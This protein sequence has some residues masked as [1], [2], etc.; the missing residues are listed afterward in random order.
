M[1]NTTRFRRFLTPLLAGLLAASAFS[2]QAKI[3]QIRFAVDP[4]YPPFES[5][6]PDGSL[7][8]FDIDL[9]NAIC[10]QLHAKCI[11]V[12]SSF[13]SMI[14]A[15]KARKFDAILSDMGITKARLKQIDFTK[16]IYNTPIRLVGPKGTHLQPTAKSLRGKRIGV[17][18]GTI[19]ENYAKLKWQGH[20]V[21]VVSYGDQEQVESDLLSGRLDAMFT[22]AVQ[23]EVGFLNQPRAKGFTLMGKAVTDPDIVGPGTAIGIR[24]GD[25]GLKTA[26]DHAVDV[27]MKDGQ[28]KKIEQKYFDI[29]IALPR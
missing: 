17:E 16:P 23:A 4:S 20:G 9:G 1:Q 15:L 11:W 10:A 8:G 13:D 29:N 26:L 14:P 24:K 2:V 18:Q 19:Q 22:D 12:E 7:V 5:K 3:T 28:F 25:K 21:D 6:Q 27:L